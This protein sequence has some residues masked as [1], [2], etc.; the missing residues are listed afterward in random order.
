MFYIMLFLFQLMSYSSA[1]TFIYKQGTFQRLIMH[2]L[3]NTIVN[4]SEL[5]YL[6]TSSDFVATNEI[7]TLDFKTKPHDI[8]T[9]YTGWV[10]G[11]L[12]DGGM[13]IHVGEYFA[14]KQQTKAFASTSPLT[15]QSSNK[16]D[17]TSIAILLDICNKAAPSKTLLTQKWQ[18][19]QNYFPM[20]TYGNI[21]FNLSK[22]I[23]VGPISLPCTSNV[24]K[25]DYNT[26]SWQEIYGWVRHAYD[27]LASQGIN[28]SQYKHRMIMLPSSKTCPWGG[29]G[30]VGCF[31]S[32]LTWYNGLAA[33]DPSTILH[34]LGHNFG[35]EHSSTP[36]NEYGDTSCP[37][38]GCCGNKCYNVPQLWG[39]GYVTPIKIFSETTIEN[40][41]WHVVDIP[42]HTLNSNNFVRLDLNTSTSYFVSF[43]SAHG[44][45][46]NMNS[47]QKYKVYV[48]ESNNIYIKTKSMLH[49]IMNEGSVYMFDN[50][51]VTLNV[52]TINT[53]HA[54]T[55]FCREPCPPFQKKKIPPSPKPQ[56]SPR[57]P[58][59][60]PS[61]PPPRS[62][63]SPFL[64]KRPP[65]PSPPPPPSSRSPFLYKR[66]PPPPPPR[67]SR[68]PFLY[69]RPPPPP[70][71][72]RSPFLY[73][74]P[75]PPP[76]SSRSPFLYKRPPPPPPPPPPSPNAPF[77]VLK[78]TIRVTPKVTRTHIQQILCPRLIQ[79]LTATTYFIVSPKCTISQQQYSVN[80]LLRNNRQQFKN[81]IS[82]NMNTFTKNTML[83]C[84]S[85]VTLYESNNQISLKYKVDA[86]VC[87]SLFPLSQ[88]N[89]KPCECV[90]V[91]A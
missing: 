51:R 61:P 24:Y 69:K 35:L 78:I 67:S 47:Y 12:D 27:I 71:S 63:R 44:F 33:L 54:E 23:I 9:G 55:A 39:L 1:S 7:Y 90:L 6:K 10:K 65:P 88:Q 87:I 5:F 49:S 25:Y 2:P 48:H 84:A 28:V 16:M 46:A 64:Y 20:C 75:P 76:R 72:S 19:I 38:G 18:I 81:Y 13:L 85:M 57:H 77:N 89:T 56:Q 32:C 22:N 53:T 40:G 82:T 62:S 60:P 26:C 15:Q 66:P 11:M 70:R 37:M 59:P 80:F 58:P 3:E 74:R 52:V 8:M 30:E 79:T 36:T 31:G 83:V 91:S 43:R 17:L 68:S 14:K 73:K 41:T 4:S 21:Q 42:G 45:D 50:L 34:E 86:N 29:L